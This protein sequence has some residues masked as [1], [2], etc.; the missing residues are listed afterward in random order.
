MEIGL[1]LGTD[2]CHGNQ[3]TILA[4]IYVPVSQQ[5][6]R[7]KN[8][9]CITGRSYF[10]INIVYVVIILMLTIAHIREIKQKYN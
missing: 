10:V 4:Y 5:K 9:N 1:N 6:M 8:A 3:V 7:P 2:G